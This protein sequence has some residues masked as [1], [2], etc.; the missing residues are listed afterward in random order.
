MSLDEAVLSHVLRSPAALRDLRRAGISEDHFVEDYQAVWRWLSRAQRKHGAVPSLEAARTRFPDLEIR[1]IRKR[2]LSVLM[3]DLQDRKIWMDFLDV[4]DEAA[5]AA[6]SPNEIRDVMA[7]AQRSMSGLLVSNG[8]SSIVD[9]FSEEGSKRMMK[10]FK[11]RKR[12]DLIGIP[13]GL[14]RF[15]LQ[16]GGL[17]RKRL[18]IVMGRP[19][20]GKSWMD[21]LFVAAAVM[22]GEKAMLFP[23]EMSL[24]DT[25]YRLFTIFSQRMYGPSKAMKNLDLTNG[26]ITKSKFRKF[27]LAVEDRFNGQLLVAD[28]GAM[29]DRYTID[30]MDAEVQLHGPGFVW[31]DYITLIKGPSGKDGVDDHTT[32]S[33][34]SKGMKQILVSND[35]AG[36]AS[37]QVNRE[38]M[39]VK[40]FLPRLEHL[41]FGDAIGQDADHV[42]SINRKGN[43]KEYLYYAEVKD[44]HGPEIGRTKVK[45]FVNEGI[46]E[47]TDEQ[48][49]DEDDD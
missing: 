13:T 31:A 24:E 49:E 7:R 33:A 36:G 42:I 41:A 4:I 20:L 27:L 12:N 23:L 46:I 45:F 48:D 35:C 10:D 18:T 15:D 22:Y 37:A 6:T 2:D 40:S 1:K 39:K 44:R 25:A 16:T 28:I 30:R 21:L 29:H 9:L 47:E 38:A 19:G 11:S 17:H 34:L 14:K 3:S 32:V 5:Q 26:R 43:N 8:D